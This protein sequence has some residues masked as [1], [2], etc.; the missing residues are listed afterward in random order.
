MTT[1]TNKALTVEAKTKI[2]SMM[3][4]DVHSDG[5]GPVDMIM[6]YC[7]EL[8]QDLDTAIEQLRDA[9]YRIYDCDGVP[10]AAIRRRHTIKFCGRPCR[11]RAWRR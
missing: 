9:G 8:S 10:F 2:T 6:E 7:S 4:A 3:I 5:V 1:M 11:A